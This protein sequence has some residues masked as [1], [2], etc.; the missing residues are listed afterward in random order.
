MG[1]WIKEEVVCSKTPDRKDVKENLTF[2][3]V[4]I[5]LTEY[6]IKY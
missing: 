3:G 5:T 4:Q 1:Q 6:R 2:L